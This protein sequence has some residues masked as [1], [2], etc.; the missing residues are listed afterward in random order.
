MEWYSTLARVYDA[1]AAA[2]AASLTI[3]R[4]NPQQVRTI[5]E[6]E[7]REKVCVVFSSG[8]ASWQGNGTKAEGLLAKEMISKCKIFVEALEHEAFCWSP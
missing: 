5:Q 7:E 8:A 3:T 2:A 4:L 6:A 1:A